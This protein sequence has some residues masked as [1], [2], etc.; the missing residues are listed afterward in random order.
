[1][2]DI[3]SFSVSTWKKEMCLLTIQENLIAED[4]KIP[5][6]AAEA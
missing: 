4:C 1:M 2:A 3:F 5:W 6:Q